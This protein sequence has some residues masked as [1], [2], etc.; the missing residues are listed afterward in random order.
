MRRLEDKVSINSLVL[1]VEHSLSMVAIVL[2]NERYRLRATMNP[3]ML[4]PVIQN[5]RC[6]FI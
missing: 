4:Q 1:I 2:S 5:A 3:F 6:S